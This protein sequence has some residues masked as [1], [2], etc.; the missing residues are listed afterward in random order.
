MNEQ[1]TRRKAVEARD[2]R[3][4]EAAHLERE[5]KKDTVRRCACGGWGVEAEEDD[6]IQHMQNDVLWLF[7]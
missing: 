6:M 5:G 3:V 1:Q 2:E 4:R 7:P